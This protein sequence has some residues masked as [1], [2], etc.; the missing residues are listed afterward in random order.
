VE[1]GRNYIHNE[2]QEELAADTSCAKH[3]VNAVLG[4][5]TIS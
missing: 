5:T 3:A 2:K 4:T 1:V